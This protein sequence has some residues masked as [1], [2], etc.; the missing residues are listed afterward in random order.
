V[1]HRPP[2]PAASAEPARWL[3]ER[4][5]VAQVS[6]HIMHPSA[7]WKKINASAPSTI[8]RQRQSHGRPRWERLNTWALE[9][10]CGIL[11]R[12]TATAQTCYFALWEVCTRP[13]RPNGDST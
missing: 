12:H 1:D 10:L 13:R 8:E 2:R 5:E 7:Q 11:A 3:T 4:I 6:G 9:A